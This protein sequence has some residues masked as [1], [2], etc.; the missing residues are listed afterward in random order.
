MKNKTFTLLMGLILCF[1]SARATAY[2]NDEGV[3]TNPTMQ[4]IQ[5][6][7]I[8]F[9]NDNEWFELGNISMSAFFDES[10]HWTTATL[11]KLENTNLAYR[12]CYEDK[13][14]VVKAKMVDGEIKCSVLIP[15]QGEKRWFSF[16]IPF[17]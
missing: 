2:R 6:T 11:Y 3:A 8:S 13:Y 10:W 15:Y 17:G 14:Y 1:G 16:I 5:I 7:P 9:K 4:K 12:V